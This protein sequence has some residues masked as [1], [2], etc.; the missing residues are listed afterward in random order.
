MWDVLTDRQNLSGS[1]DHESLNP[2]VS[3]GSEQKRC[4]CL[5]QLFKVRPH[6]LSELP[7]ERSVSPGESYH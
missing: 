2:E 1:V 7:P 5:S 3:K 6:L 4:S